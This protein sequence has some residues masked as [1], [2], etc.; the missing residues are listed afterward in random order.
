MARASP[1]QSSF[2]AGEFSPRMEGRVDISKYGSA[3]KILEGFI[4][5]IQGPAQRRGGTRF[6]AEIKD[7][8]VRSWLVRFEFN[9]T[10][11]YQLEFGNGYIRF[12]AN[13]GQVVVSGVSFYNG[14]TNYVVG[15]L[16]SQAGV[17]YYCILATVGNAPPNATFWYPLTG[18]IYEI[19]SPFQTAQRAGENFRLRQSDRQSGTGSEF[20]RLTR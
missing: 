5:L 17:N 20:R 4:P 13:H 14:A 9:T 7:S 18:S 1:L 12:W 16:V 19:P 15:D 6:V 11:A 8:S 2:N 10:Q 3:C